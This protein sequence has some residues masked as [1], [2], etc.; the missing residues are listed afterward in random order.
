M[1]NPALGQQQ[2]GLRQFNKHVIP[3]YR[4]GAY[5][6]VEY[7]ENLKIWSK[8]AR[9]DDEQIGPAIMARIEQGALTFARL[10]T[11]TH[12]DPKTYTIVSYKGVDALCL[13]AQAPVTDGA[14]N[15]LQDEQAHP[16]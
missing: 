4:P 6:I 5:P 16:S 10:Y 11:L 12:L 2:P 8:L 14:G 15:V 13:P 7:E 3:G 1:A 9:L